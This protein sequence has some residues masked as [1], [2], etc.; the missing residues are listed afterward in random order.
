MIQPMRIVLRRATPVTAI[1]DATGWVALIEGGGRLPVVCWALC[2]DE[3]LALVQEGG[4]LKPA[5]D[6]GWFQRLE[7]PA[8]VSA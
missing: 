1:A 3:L 5:E 2:G 8:R 6:L 4:A 7:S